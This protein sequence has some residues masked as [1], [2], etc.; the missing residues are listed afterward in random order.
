VLKPSEIVKY[1]YVYIYHIY[2]YE[3]IYI[4]IQVLDPSE[5]AKYSRKHPKIYLGGWKNIGNYLHIYIY[6]CTYIDTYIYEKYL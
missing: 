4:Y 5:I 3:Y 6:K 2:E 1:I